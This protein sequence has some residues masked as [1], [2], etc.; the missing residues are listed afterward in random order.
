M[1]RKRNKS[2]Y[3]KSFY[4]I[5]LPLPRK[6]NCPISGI[7]LH[8]TVSSRFPRNS[9]WLATTR[10]IATANEFSKPDIQI[11]PSDTR[12]FAREIRSQ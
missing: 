10:R 9:Q 5:T 3:A 2:N 7:T 8:T 4:R 1:T 12:K 6:H 11:D